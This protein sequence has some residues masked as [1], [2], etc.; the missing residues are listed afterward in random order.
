MNEGENTRTRVSVPAAS[1]AVASPRPSRWSHALAALL[2]VG[3]TFVAYLPALRGGYVWDDN[4]HLLD[5]PVLQ[6]GGLAKAGCPARTST[7]LAADVQHVLVGGQ[8]LGR[9]PSDG[10]SP[11]QY[12]SARRVRPPSRVLLR[13]QF[14]GASGKEP[15]SDETQGPCLN[16]AEGLQGWGAL[17]GAAIFAIAPGQRRERGVGG[18]TQE[19]LLLFLT[20]L[21][22]WLYLRHEGTGRWEVYAWR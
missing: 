21:A 1:T 17:F 22:V 4:L 2:L 3:A 20:L 10:L 18:P 5:N 11:R 6:P 14:P 15:A 9:C 12:L 16:A 8:T 19:R 13:V 7:I